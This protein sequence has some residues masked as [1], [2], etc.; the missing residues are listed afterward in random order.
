[1]IAAMLAVR[2][3]TRYSRA[4]LL[5]L[6]LAPF[7]STALSSC[8][9]CENASGPLAFATVLYTS[10]RVYLFSPGASQFGTPSLYALRASDGKELWHAQ[11][12]LQAS[13]ADHLY[14]NPDQHNVYVLEAL[15]PSDGKVLWQSRQPVQFRTVGA[16]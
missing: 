6:L 9:N 10:G 16:L 1:E 12:V 11:G 3:F 2:H 5:P 14:L 7:L 8:L 4:W 15:R 13:D